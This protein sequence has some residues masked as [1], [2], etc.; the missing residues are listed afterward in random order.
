MRRD[1][2]ASGLQYLRS[3]SAVVLLAHDI[4][5]HRVPPERQ[6]SCR[7][8]IERRALVDSVYGLVIL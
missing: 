3:P 6:F 1:I 5:S 2:N 7:L 4:A 8:A